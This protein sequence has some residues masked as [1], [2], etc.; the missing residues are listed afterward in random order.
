VKYN[1]KSRV[2]STD[3]IPPEGVRA[4]F[5]IL[6]ECTV[7]VVHDWQM[8]RTTFCDGSSAEVWVMGI[9]PAEGRGWCEA[10]GY[11]DLW[12][13]LREHDLI[14]TWLAVRMGYPHSPTLWTVAHAGQT[15][16]GMLDRVGIDAEEWLVTEFQRYLNTG[17]RDEYPLRWLEERG[18]DP[19]ALKA[20]ALAFFRG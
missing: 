11:A 20:E 18:L 16:Y 5:L 10:L 6:G 15:I 13:H 1:A 3:E 17:E 9:D 12:D 7:T 14:H 4:S 19:A 8:A 2:V